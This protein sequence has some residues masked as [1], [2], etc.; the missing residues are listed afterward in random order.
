MTFTGS[1]Y[2]RNPKNIVDPEEDEE[3]LN[4]MDILKD[5]YIEPRVFVI[6]NDNTGVEL[7]SD[8]QLQKGYFDV[9]SKNKSSNPT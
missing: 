8:N 9:F 7:L 6:S 1:K 3:N 5:D 4:E 2:Q